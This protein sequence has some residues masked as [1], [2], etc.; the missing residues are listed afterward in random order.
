MNQSAPD[1]ES[2]LRISLTPVL[3]VLVVCGLALIL[4]SPY[5]PSDRPLAL[6]ILLLLVTAIA[7]ALENRGYRAGR[8]L[9]ILALI[10]GVYL[11]NSLPGMPNS[12][13]LVAVPTTLAAPLISLSAAIALAAGESLLFVVLLKYPVAGLE[14]SAVIIA[15]IA[16][17]AMFG[18]VVAVYRPTRQ[19]SE[20]VEEYFERAQLLLEEARDHRAELE[21]ALEDLAHATRQLALTNERTA[22]LRMIAEEAQKTKAA[23]VAKVSHELR[24]P[25]NMIIGLADLLMETPE[26]YG[27]L[28][29]AL[30]EDLGIVHRNCEHLS[31]LIDDVLAL[32]QAEAGRLTLHRENVNLRDVI[33][34]SL[35]VVHPLLEKKELG[36]QL[37][38]PD[39]LPAVY[40]DRTRIR[41]VI[42]NLVSNAARFT[43]EGGIAIHVARQDQHVVVSVAD[44]GPGIAREDAE[45]IFEPFC[46]GMGRPWRDKGGSG[47]GLS[48]S[49]QFVELHGGRIWFE[50]ELGI[51][52]TFSFELPISLPME[53]VAGPGRWI[54]E[55]W[56]WVERA[57]K[58]DLSA[59]TFNP[60]VIVCDETGD[61]Y[62]T[63]GRYADGVEFVDTK[64]VIQATQELQR[65][66]AHAVLLNTASPDSL[67]SLVESARQAIPDTPLIGCSVPP[68]IE[69]AL[70][71]GA[72]DYLVKP[73]TRADL[74][75]VIAD[76]YIRRVIGRP[77][78][79]VLVVDDDPDVLVLLTRLLHACDDTLEVVTAR[80]GKQA[81]EELRGSSPDFVLLDIVMPDLDGW[82]VLELKNR[83]ETIRDIPVILVSAQ[84]PTEQ[85]RGSRLVVATMG[86][87]L[88]LSK[89]LHC[90]LELSALLL[91]PD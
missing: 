54:S 85:P 75:K 68:Q 27:G 38:V 52:T 84:D 88:S 9:V 60:R 58:A 73:V 18:V 26:V 70:E 90:S 74:Q 29:P 17:W 8:W 13:A 36:L 78:K 1:F 6:G 39:D 63:L 20:W 55:N 44:T 82:Q 53:H 62:L 69:R 15:L 81:L 77:L 80:N 22:V 2:E 42:L 12:L 14:S 7:W 45:R 33:D 89:V 5:D 50:T 4:A 3:V 25:L 57:S 19:L 21:Q 43:E 31:S 35:T 28:S 47:L 34:E 23:F 61:L 87:G 16:I 67:C 71:A 24:T 79:R 51:G 56:A 41:Q 66:P 11:A 86:E 10:V 48:I 37:A 46:Q 65:S 49:K 91:K 40:C 76:E 32:S 30:L 64:N 72:V 59:S 83:D